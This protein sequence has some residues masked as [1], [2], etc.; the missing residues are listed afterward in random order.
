LRRLSLNNSHLAACGFAGVFTSAALNTSSGL[1]EVSE[2]SSRVQGVGT[3]L[4]AVAPKKTYETP[5]LG[6]RPD[7]P[8]TSS[9][10]KFLLVHSLPLGFEW[11]SLPPSFPVTIHSPLFLPGHCLC[12]KWW[13]GSGCCLVSSA[14]ASEQA[15]TM[16]IRA[17]RRNVCG[18]WANMTMLG[19]LNSLQNAT[20][21]VDRGPLRARID[22]PVS[23]CLSH[24]AMNLKRLG[25]FVVHCTRLSLGGSCIC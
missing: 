2:G 14:G 22:P 5:T 6:C 9:K 16:F 13:Q 23:E 25:F 1:V 3:S 12:T 15:S 17:H 19:A 20:F 4:G 21:V 18:R 8:G 10:P 24:S 7:H 11:H